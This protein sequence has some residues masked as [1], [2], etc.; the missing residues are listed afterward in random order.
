MI[1]ELGKVVEE[2]RFPR[3]FGFN[4]DTVSPPM[5]WPS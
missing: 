4:Q 3:T 1:K 5:Y 2:T